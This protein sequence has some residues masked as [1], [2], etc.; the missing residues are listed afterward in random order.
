MTDFINEF[1]VQESYK[2]YYKNLIEELVKEYDSQ[3]IHPVKENVF[4]MLRMMNSTDVK[5]VVIGPEP[6][7]YFYQEGNST[8]SHANG[9]AFSSYSKNPPM[10]T[11][12][13]ASDIA[14]GE[15]KP[16]WTMNSYIEKGYFFINRAMTVRHGRPRSHHD[17][18]FKWYIFIDNLIKFIE[19]KNKNNKVYVCYGTTARIDKIKLNKNSRKVYRDAPG[20]KKY[21]KETQLS[22][23]YSDIETYTGIKK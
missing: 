7:G 1:L 10:S 13:I 20:Y 14:Q 2:N 3:I 12:A 22:V 15:N 18:R 19:E 17:K 8:F 11:K 4:K 6:Y 9:I 23:D 21:N 5:V 16:D